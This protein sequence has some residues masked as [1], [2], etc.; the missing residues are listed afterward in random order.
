MDNLNRLVLTADRWL[1]EGKPAREA[2][3]VLESV[4]TTMKDLRIGYGV[5]YDLDYLTLFHT[6]MEAIVL[7]VKGKTP[8]TLSE[9][10]LALLWAQADAAQV[11]WTTLVEKARFDEKLYGL[12]AEQAQRL[13]DEIKVEAVVLADLRAALER[14]DKAAVITAATALKPHFKAIYTTFGDFNAVK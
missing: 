10:D 12:S 7:A 2:H 8:D 5:E 13:R 11:N 4:R 9:A 1:L 3:G 14:G 6:P